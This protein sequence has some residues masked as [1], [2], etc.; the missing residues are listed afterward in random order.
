M[1]VTSA[2]AEATRTVA[3]SEALV[4]SRAAELIAKGGDSRVLVLRAQPRWPGGDLTIDGQRVRVVEGISQLAILDAYAA[5][6][7]DEYLV[8]LID[9]PRSDV[10][11]TVLARAY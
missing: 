6:A 9:R 1:G 10:G 4:R 3:V 2:P 11:D 7:E 8:V 5:Q